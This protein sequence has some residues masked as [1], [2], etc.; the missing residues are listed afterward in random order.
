MKK[1]WS[2]L[3]RRPVSSRCQYKTVLSCPTVVSCPYLDN[4]S[5]NSVFANGR[6]SGGSLCRITA[7]VSIVVSQ[8]CHFVEFR[9]TEQL[10]KD[11]AKIKANIQLVLEVSFLCVMSFR[12]V[13]SQQSV[14]NVLSA[15]ID[16]S[17]CFALAFLDFCTNLFPNCPPEMFHSPN[18]HL[19]WWWNRTVNLDEASVKPVSD[20]LCF[21]LR[22]CGSSRACQSYQRSGEET[23]CSLVLV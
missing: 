18:E 4:P 16:L 11:S 12:T 13:Q 23:F 9:F 3:K 5:V 10:T 19:F 8:P 15:F 22:V 21:S 14:R 2:S 7:A 17:R 20:G 6:R 1:P